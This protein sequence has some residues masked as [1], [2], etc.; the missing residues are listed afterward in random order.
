MLM[1]TAPTSGHDGK[2]Y[3]ACRI[4]HCL[5][6]TLIGQQVVT[7]GLVGD[8][9]FFAAG[10][11]TVHQFQESAGI[12]SQAPRWAQRGGSAVSLCQAPKQATNGHRHVEKSDA[13]GL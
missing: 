12:E 2:P 9:G 6:N 8:D 5:G 4:R 3:T 13:H 7:L 10:F 1:H 11:G